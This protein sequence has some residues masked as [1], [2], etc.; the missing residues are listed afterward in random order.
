MS[1]S[2][3]R[4]S[5]FMLMALGCCH[6]LWT[7]SC[8][9]W[10]H[11]YLLMEGM[12]RSSRIRIICNIRCMG[13]KIKVNGCR[14]TDYVSVTQY[15]LNSSQEKLKRTQSELLFLQQ[16]SQIIE[17]HSLVSPQKAQEQM[18]QNPMVQLN[19]PWK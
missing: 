15:Y 3:G 1:Y 2:G 19:P 9:I 12:I 7:I 14:T 8:S 18:Q 13:P 16:D 4:W 5:V 17:H 10:R 11:C 6:V